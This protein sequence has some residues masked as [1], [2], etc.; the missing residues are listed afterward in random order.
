[1]PETIRQGGE[2]LLA[3][4]IRL[5]FPPTANHHWKSA[6]IDGRL[7]TYLS[8]EGRKYRRAVYFSLRARRPQPVMLTDS[9]AVEIDL[10]EP[11]RKD[12]SRSTKT[13]DIDNRIK[14]LLDAL[15]HA[16]VW[17]D[18]SLVS[19]LMVERREQVPGGCVIVRIRPIE[20]ETVA[21]VDDP[22]V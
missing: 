3:S 19:R 20:Q 8:S 11:T 7:R 6:V 2:A 21:R 18:D 9:V 15:T 17:E 1:M 10:H 4:G 16:G 22:A 14:P 5:P 13:L 12:G